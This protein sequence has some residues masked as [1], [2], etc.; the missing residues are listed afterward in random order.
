[1]YRKPFVTYVI[2]VNVLLDLKNLLNLTDE[3]NK[4]DTEELLLHEQLSVICWLLNL[5]HDPFSFKVAFIFNMVTIW[6]LK[7]RRGRSG[8]RRD[9]VGGFFGCIESNFVLIFLL[10][11]NSLISLKSVENANTNDFYV[12]I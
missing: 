9:K 10:L 6:L 5:L 8:R 12:G 11:F 2:L 4:S 7:Y 3:K 1:M